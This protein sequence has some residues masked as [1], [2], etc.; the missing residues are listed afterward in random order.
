MSQIQRADVDEAVLRLIRVLEPRVGKRMTGVVVQNLVRLAESGATPMQVL[1][2]THQHLDAYAR[3]P[4]SGT[5]FP[6]GVAKAIADLGCLKLPFHNGRRGRAHGMASLAMSDVEAAAIAQHADALLPSYG[7]DDAD[8]AVRVAYKNAHHYRLHLVVGRTYNRNDG[9]PTELLADAWRAQGARGTPVALV[10]D[11]VGPAGV[12]YALGDA[13]STT[14]SERTRSAGFVFEPHRGD[15]LSL[16]DVAG[17]Q[18]FF[19]QHP[20][21]VTPQTLAWLVHLVRLAFPLDTVDVDDGLTVL[22][23]PLE[24]LALTAA[25]ELLGL[26]APPPETR[27]TVVI[28]AGSTTVSYG[29]GELRL[30]G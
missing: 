5:P 3:I 8:F 12:I 16:D 30:S 13:P 21:P 23:E 29:A 18:R 10:P 19:A 27:D 11:D 15:P 6:L 1:S 28:R 2:A 20:L 26:R 14:L 7:A 24:E 9:A 4:E 22:W 17:L 25:S